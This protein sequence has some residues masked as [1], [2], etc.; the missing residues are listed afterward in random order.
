MG[1][2]LTL[3]ICYTRL[4]F[5]KVEIHH[6][7]NSLYAYT[8]FLGGRQ[9]QSRLLRQ[10]LWYLPFSLLWYEAQPTI[11]RLTESLMESFRTL[12]NDREASSIL[13]QCIYAPTFWGSRRIIRINTCFHCRNSQHRYGSPS[14]KWMSST[15][16]CATC[17]TWVAAPIPEAPAYIQG[18]LAFPSINTPR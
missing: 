9:P 17:Y 7:E 5:L 18:G 12:G 16:F 2:R 13:L 3:T 8:L 4:R 11:I 14:P 10:L 15:L 6:P 1:I